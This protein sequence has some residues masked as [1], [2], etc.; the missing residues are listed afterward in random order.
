MTVH[1]KW[2]CRRGGHSMEWQTGLLN[3]RRSCWLL[4]MPWLTSASASREATYL[5]APRPVTRLCL[6]CDKRRAWQRSNV[7]ERTAP[8]WRGL[9]HSAHVLR[10]W[11]GKGGRFTSLELEY[12]LLR[13]ADCAGVDDHHSMLRSLWA[14]AGCGLSL[15]S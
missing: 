6:V 2:T 13:R 8:M 15:G 10:S 11:K 12:R 7:G 3:V 14:C 1:Y 9:H 4:S 5:Q